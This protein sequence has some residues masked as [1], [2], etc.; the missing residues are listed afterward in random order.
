[1]LYTPI[2]VLSVH[3]LHVSFSTEGPAVHTAV[4]YAE[5]EQVSDVIHKVLSLTNAKDSNIESES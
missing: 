5:F 2:S 3:G 1:M 4:S